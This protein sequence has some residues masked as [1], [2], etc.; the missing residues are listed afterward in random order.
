MEKVSAQ[1]QQDRR[2]RGFQCPSC[3]VLTW[4]GFTGWKTHCTFTQSN[5]GGT[6][7]KC[8]CFCSHEG[9]RGPMAFA[10][11]S[12]VEFCAL[13]VSVCSNPCLFRKN[14]PSPE[15][16]TT[17]RGPHKRRTANTHGSL[18]VDVVA[19]EVMLT[20]FPRGAKKHSSA[21]PCAST[22]DTVFLV[23]K[24]CM[25]YIRVYCGVPV[26]VFMAVVFPGRQ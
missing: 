9:S 1:V 8:G 24:L 6:Q 16:R 12:I 10:P 23:N 18:V 19:P 17:K 13:Q 20:V 21:A 22:H 25:K 7:K 15:K 5:G 3:R 26:V 11:T 2:F 14:D 4:P